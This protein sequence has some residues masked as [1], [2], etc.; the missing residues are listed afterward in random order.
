MVKPLV[1]DPMFLAQKAVPATEEDR[2]VITDLCDT[3][4]A[5]LD[6]CVGMAANMIGVNKNIIVISL[7]FA[8]LALVN[9]RITKK[10]KPYQAE[11]GCLS[12]LGG[13]KK[14]TRYGEIEVE[15]MD[16]DFK[17]KKEKFSG[18]PAQ[19]IQHELDHVAGI[20]I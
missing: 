12:F 3:L 1:H 8:Q 6:G 19:I 20:L 14:T 15:Y 4:R 18:F 11:E 2:Q 17:L 10:S 7:G 16:T 5:H 9:A 13:P